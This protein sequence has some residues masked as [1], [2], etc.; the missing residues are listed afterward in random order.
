MRSGAAA[1]ILAA[2][3]VASGCSSTAGS[4]NDG[5]ADLTYWLWQSNQQPAYQSCADKFH[6]ANPNIKV[7]IE[8]YAW[9]DYWDKL[10]TSLASGSGPDV[11]TDHLAKY[12][13]FVAKQ[14]ILPID[15][16]V[17]TDSVP[18]DIYQPGLADLW[19]H[20]DGHRYGLPKDFDTVAYFYNTKMF[21][22]AGITKDQAAAWTW[23]PQD[24]GSLEK[25]IAHL[26]VDKNGK[27]GDEPGFDKSKVKTYG[28]SAGEG[29]GGPYGQQ[30]WSAY[31]A[32]TGWTFTDKNP[33]GTHYNYD[34]QRFQDTVAWYH[35]LMDKGYMNPLETTTGSD[36]VANFGA[37]KFAMAMDGDWNTEAYFGL[38]DVKV[39]IAPTPVGPS[40]KRASMYNGL[41]DA[42]NASTSH[43]DAAWK[44]V[45]YLASADCQNVVGQ[46]GV[47]FPAI[48]QATD[49]A[50][51]A[52]QAKGVDVDAF[53]VHVKDHT[54]FLFPITDNAA[55]VNTIMT[56][57][58]DAILSGKKA[59]SDLKQANDQVNALFK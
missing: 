9:G 12:A 14:Q 29:S 21:Q 53:L 26:T 18:T 13:D 20:K 56:T 10:T 46:T 40:G 51:A 48:P 36:P 43:K 41:S 4:N 58:M 33:W 57:E 5:S 47:V 2:G 16:M 37:G 25:A 27:R 30:Y 34:D 28:L 15:D 24:G 55:D 11:F 38:K 7:T 39:D 19:V 31:A 59:A 17:K 49:K 8:Q 35:S 23:N 32:S 54:T 42:I 45:K 22:D 52:F 1:A 6:T 50:Q 3:L 44:W